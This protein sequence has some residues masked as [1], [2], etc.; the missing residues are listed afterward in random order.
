ML[1]FHACGVYFAFKTSVGEMSASIFQNLSNQLPKTDL[2][3]KFGISI[4]VEEVKEMAEEIL[5]ELNTC[6]EEYYATLQSGNE[7]NVEQVMNKSQQILKNKRKIKFPVFY[8]TKE[9]LKMKF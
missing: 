5:Q 9:M 4:T 2:P 8:N 1:L 3:S 7:D 6:L